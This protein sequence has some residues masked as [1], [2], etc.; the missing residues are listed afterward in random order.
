MNDQW[1]L[2]LGAIIL[3][4]IFIISSNNLISSNNSRVTENEFVLTGIGYGQSLIDEVKTKYF[5]VIQNPLNQSQLTTDLGP[6]VGEQGI[7]SIPDKFDTGIQGFESDTLFNDVDDYNGYYRVISSPRYG[8]YRL[9]VQV[10]YASEA[11]PEVGSGGVKTF[12]KKMV[13][14]VNNKYIDSVNSPVKLDY[15]FVLY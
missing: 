1:L 3:L 8:D 13:V 10:Y 4:G 14:N 2:T 15:L 7:I 9:K 11:N 5:D 12:Y 6:E